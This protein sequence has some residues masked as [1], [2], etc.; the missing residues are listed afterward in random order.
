MPV[1]RA[2][3]KVPSLSSFTRMWHC[4]SGHRVCSSKPADAGKEQD[5]NISLQAKSKHSTVN[6]KHVHSSTVQCTQSRER[7]LRRKTA[8]EIS[9][10]WH[11]NLYTLNMQLPCMA[12]STDS[13]NASSFQFTVPENPCLGLFTQVYLKL[14]AFWLRFV[15]KWYNSHSVRIVSIHDRH[16]RPR[17]PW[18]GRKCPLK[19]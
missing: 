7:E 9:Q 10:F 6:S 8:R 12:I 2:G 5:T 1:L 19:M 11:G 4:H 17:P 16:Y 3:R 14:L 18:L 15:H 13:W